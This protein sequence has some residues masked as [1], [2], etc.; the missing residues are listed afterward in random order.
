MFSELLHRL[1]FPTLV[2]TIIGSLWT[3]GWCQAVIAEADRHSWPALAVPGH[4]IQASDLSETADGGFR[5]CSGRSFHQI[6]LKNDQ[7][8]RVR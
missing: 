3:V 2:T 8:I 1:L 5:P 7:I 4:E 6:F